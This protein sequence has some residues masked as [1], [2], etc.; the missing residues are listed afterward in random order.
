MRIILILAI[1]LALS[2]VS[3]AKEHKNIGGLNPDKLRVLSPAGDYELWNED[4]IFVINPRGI[5]GAFFSDDIPEL[6]SSLEHNAR[7]AVWS[8]DSRMVA[9][10]IRTGKEIEDSFVLLRQPKDEWRCLRLPCDDP[11]AHAV[12]LRWLDATTVVIEISGSYG[13]KSTEE[14]VMAHY[15]YTMTLKYDRKKNRFIKAS[16]TKPRYPYQDK[17]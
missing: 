14:S 6:E 2:T 11:D 1:M 13:G 16:E 9:V 10:C 4:E 15:V 7:Y 12:P 8:P 17:T 5:D 3:Y